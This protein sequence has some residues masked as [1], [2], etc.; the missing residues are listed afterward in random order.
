M[1][2]RIWFIDQCHFSADMLQYV[3]MTSPY[4]LPPKPRISKSLLQTLGTSRDFW[5][6]SYRYL[7]FWFIGQNLSF[8]DMLRYIFTTSSYLLPPKP[9]FSRSLLQ[10]Q[11][12]WRV[13]WHSS[14]RYF[15][16]WFG[17][18]HSFADIIQHFL[19]LPHNCYLWNQGLQGHYFKHKEPQGYSNL[20]L[21]YIQ[22]SGLMDN[23][24]PS[25]TWYRTIPWLPHTCYLL[26][27][28][29]QCH[30]FKHN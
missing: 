19:R 16:F 4:L 1:Y 9:R 25:Q 18:C 23:V 13:F 27:Q 24:I 7:R 15:W 26:K 12:T 17:Q 11:G 6:F 8:A 28:G 30:Y 5:H 21:T 14:Y 3:F 29:F 22:S 20:Y 2:L 10:T